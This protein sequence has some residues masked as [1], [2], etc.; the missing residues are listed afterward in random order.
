MN[1]VEQGID[2]NGLNARLPDNYDQPPDTETGFKTMNTPVIHEWLFS[3][4]YRRPM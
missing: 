2:L 4:T 3:S 1:P